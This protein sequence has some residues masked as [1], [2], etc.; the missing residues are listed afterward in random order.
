MSRKIS[1]FFILTILFTPCLFAQDSGDGSEAHTRAEQ[2]EEE[3]AKKAASISRATIPPAEGYVG[4]FVDFVS[5]VPLTFHVDGLGP[6][7]GA[8]IG[9][10]HQFADSKDRIRSAV[11][12]TI[13]LHEFYSAGVHAELRA[14]RSRDLRFAVDGWHSDSPQLLYF[15]P[16][17]DSSIQNRTDFRREVTQFGLQ[18]SLRQRPHLAEACRLNEM[19]VNVGPGTNSSL[20]S[21]ETVFGPAQA[22]GI[23]VQSNFLIGGCSAELEMRDL[24]ADPHKGVYATALYDRY[25]AQKTDV[26]SYHRVSILGEQ[27]VPFW[28]K[29]RVIALREKTDLSFHSDSQ[30]VPFYLQPTL[31]SDT[32]LRGFTRYRFYDEN[33]ISLNLEY[34]WQIH[35]G[36]DMVGFFDAGKVFHRPGEI[37]LVGLESSAGFGFRAIGQRGLI[38][39]ADVGFSREGVQLWFKFGSWPWPR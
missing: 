31:G 22:P 24:P 26:F 7:Y 9:Y 20:P 21:T 37:S 13:W 17:P 6:G 12:G 3:Q 1:V 15:G 25:G 36:F 39:R 35:T 33:A 10:V 4:R 27:Y 23:D 28:N 19:L 14:S 34:R 18:V 8:A 11:W 29:K 2:I 32:D 38:A 30:V 5:R 16:G